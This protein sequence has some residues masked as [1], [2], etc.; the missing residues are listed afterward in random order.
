MPGIAA[1]WTI[2]KDF[3]IK[4]TIMH[5]SNKLSM[6]GRCYD[7]ADDSGAL[8]EFLEKSTTRFKATIEIF[9]FFRFGNG[10]RKHLM[11]LMNYDLVIQIFEKP[12]DFGFFVPRSFERK[13]KGAADSDPNVPAGFLF[14]AFMN[15]IYFSL[16]A[17]I[18][19]KTVPFLFQKCSER[20]K[21]LLQYEFFWHKN[22]SMPA[23]KASRD[24]DLQAMAMKT[25]KKETDKF[26]SI[27]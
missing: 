27:V 15:E 6:L 2:N 22:I 3:L 9:G 20:S 4:T 7:I 1:L 25:E 14:F 12:K 11:E 24:R 18:K 13:L 19:N 23:A 16:D 21:K 5:H 8:D 10:F 26:R 17:S